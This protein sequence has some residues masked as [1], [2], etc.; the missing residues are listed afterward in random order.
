MQSKYNTNQNRC[1]EEKPINPKITRNF[2][3]TVPNRVNQPLA[4][5]STTLCLLHLLPRS[6]L[7]HSNARIILLLA[8]KSPTSAT[9]GSALPGCASWPIISGRHTPLWKTLGKTGHRL[10]TT[11][12]FSDAFR[13]IYGPFR[14]NSSACLLGVLAACDCRIGPLRVKSE[15]RE[16]DIL[17]EEENWSRGGI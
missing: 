8:D 4:T 2:S 6:T 9:N 14:G 13:A 1:K 12:R 16:A 10:W 3:K 7:I 11:P 5:A 15:F 17:S